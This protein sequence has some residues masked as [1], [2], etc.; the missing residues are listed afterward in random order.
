MNSGVSPSV[1]SGREGP[2]AGARRLPSRRGRRDIDWPAIEQD[3][4]AG[5]LS[6]R[7]LAEKHDCAHSTIANHA[8]RHCWKRV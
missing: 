4:R 2:S 6:L 5:L 8:G 3:Y 7:D 1:F